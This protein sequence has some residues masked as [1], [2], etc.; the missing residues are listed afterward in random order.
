MDTYADEIVP[1][2]A[3]AHASVKIAPKAQLKVYPGAPHGLCSTHKD[4][5]NAICWSSSGDGRD[6]RPDLRRFHTAIGL[7][8]SLCGVIALARDK[9]ISAR[10]DYAEAATRS[11]SIGQW[12]CA[13]DARSSACDIVARREHRS[14]ID[15]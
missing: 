10:M 1:I 11:G 4:K 15:S 12:R 3:S 2:G 6:G 5:V 13:A 8:A 14:H 9:E 7:M